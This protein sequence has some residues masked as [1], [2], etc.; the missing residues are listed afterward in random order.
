MLH[1]T[2][3]SEAS[4]RQGPAPL[5]RVKNRCGWESP[6]PADGGRD[7]VVLV[8]KSQP[9]E[10]PCITCGKPAHQTI[11]P[12][13]EARIQGEAIEKKTVIEK[14]GRPEQGRR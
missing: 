4:P 9:A 5:K 14:K 10:R 2:P 6:S 8:R 1:F 12:A 7:A 13:C 3:K 11:C